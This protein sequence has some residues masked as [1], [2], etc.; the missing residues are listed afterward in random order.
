VIAAMC[1][2]GSCRVLA[3][4]ASAPGA[5]CDAGARACPIDI[6]FTAN[7]AVVSGVLSP[8]RGSLSYAFATT[9]SARLQWVMSGPAVRVVLSYPDGNT[10]G[11]GLPSEI[12]LAMPGRYVFTVSSNTMAE[13]IYG[14]FQ[15]EFRMLAPN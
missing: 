15:L 14:S 12:T 1:A 2:I 7:R 8:K 13:H 5:T 6:A 9:A 10:D 3:P 11:P 4:Q